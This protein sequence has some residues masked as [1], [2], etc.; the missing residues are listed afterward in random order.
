MGEGVAGQDVGG[1]QNE[2]REDDA[3]HVME[4]GNLASSDEEDDADQALDE[5]GR[6]QVCQDPPEV[7]PRPSAD[8]PCA[9]TPQP[10]AGE[11]NDDRPPQDQVNQTHQPAAISRLDEGTELRG[12]GPRDPV[13]RSVRG[14]RVADRRGRSGADAGA[15]PP[16]RPG[17]G[18]AG[19]TGPPGSHETGP[20]AS[21]GAGP[22][23]S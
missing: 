20:P 2:D 19:P 21:R 6:L 15:S 9:Q 1:E 14:D 17:P 12:T 5:Q 11:T 22:A 3:V 8:D 23:R 18:H 13:A 7:S 16:A 10:Q 4:D